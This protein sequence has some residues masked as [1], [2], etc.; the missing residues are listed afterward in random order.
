[1]QPRRGVSPGCARSSVDRRIRPPA[2]YLRRLLEVDGDCLLRDRRDVVGDGNAHRLEELLL[3]GVGLLSHG[4]VLIAEI[5]PEAAQ[6][7]HELRTGPAARGE[8]KP[9]SAPRLVN[10]LPPGEPCLLSLILLP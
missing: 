5:L 2:E 9:L 10:R 4:D 1:M 7:S 8:G 6:E 3:P